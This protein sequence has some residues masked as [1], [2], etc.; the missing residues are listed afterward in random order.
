MGELAGIPAQAS[1]IFVK[2]F[3]KKWLAMKGLF[4]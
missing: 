3:A 4:V 2:F 1:S